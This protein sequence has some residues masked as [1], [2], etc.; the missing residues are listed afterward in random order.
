MK[1]EN[2][3]GIG[4]FNRYALFLEESEDPLE[5]LK[6]EEQE[7]ELLKKKKSQEKENKTSTKGSTGKPKIST[8]STRVEKSTHKEEPPRDRPVRSGGASDRGERIQR[9]E[10]RSFDDEKTKRPPREGGGRGGG[11]EI[12]R[13]YDRP[14]RS[15]PPNGGFSNF[16][17]ESGG[18]GRG[19]GGFRGRGGRGGRGGGRGRGAG[20]REFDRRSGSDKTGI[21]PMEKKEG[22]GAYNWGKESDFETQ[23]AEGGTNFDDSWA[24][25]NGE[26]HL[27]GDEE[28]KEE[29]EVNGEKHESTEEEK[30][31]PEPEVLTLDEWK[32]RQMPREQPKFN[33]RKVDDKGLKGMKKLEKEKTDED[34]ETDDED[35]EEYQQRARDKKVLD[36]PIMFSQPHFRGG[37]RG[38]RGGRGS[39]DGPRSDRGGRGGFPGGDGGI[40]GGGRGGGMG[41][42]EPRGRGEGRGRGGG[43]RGRGRGEGGRGS[44]GGFRGS[45]GGGAN[46][47]PPVMND[48]A[49]FPSLA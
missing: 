39:G 6:K 10:R 8:D 1:M 4:V 34:E 42:G 48:E 45:Q 25:K 17:T 35:Y 12:Q 33:I 46:E 30:P 27:S 16:E 31:E 28:K 47:A 5:I 24:E 43:G 15:G 20:G 7:R 49:A 18:P 13:S 3:Y 44:R 11:M 37:G 32:A 38:F 14:D 23:I 41:G 19:R 22:G 36:I 29:P 9:G 40:R 21:K 26:Q 2:S